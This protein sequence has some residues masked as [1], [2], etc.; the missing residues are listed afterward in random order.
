MDY[1][2]AVVGMII[3][4]I[5]FYKWGSDRRY[6]RKD[7]WQIKERMLLNLDHFEFADLEVKKINLFLDWFE[8]REAGENP[9]IPSFMELEVE[10]DNEPKIIIP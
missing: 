10:V 5:A 7:F 6:N 1:G 2:Y 3:T 8:R 9:P 4:A